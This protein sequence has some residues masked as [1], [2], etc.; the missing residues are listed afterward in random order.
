MTVLEHRPWPACKICSVY[1]VHSKVRQGH[2]F[3]WCDRVDIDQIK[4][5]PSP[6]TIK[7][8]SYSTTL[9]VI[10]TDHKN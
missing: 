3:P 6:K 7:L 9:H 2:K 10:S 4:Q 5:T 1:N 8:F